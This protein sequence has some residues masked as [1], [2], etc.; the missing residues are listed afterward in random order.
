MARNKDQFQTIRSQGVMLPPDVLQRV[1]LLELDGL[2]PDDFHLPPSIRLNEAISQSWSRVLAFWKSFSEAK[3]RISEADN[4]GSLITRERWLLPLFQELGYGRLTAKKAPE[5][6]GNLYPIER[7]WQDVPIHLVGCKLSM[8][9]RAKGVRGAATASPHSLVQEFLNRSDDHLWAFVSNGLQLRILRDNLTLS[10]QSF[11]EFNLEAMMDGEVYADFALLWVL[12]HQSRLEAEKPE[13]YWLEK[14]SKVAQEQGTRILSDLRDGVTRSIEALGTG[15]VSHRKNDHLRQ[16]LENGDLSTQDYYRQLLRIIYRLLFLFVSEDRELLHTS[17]SDEQA[18]VLYDNNYS[19]RHLRDLA[20][21]FRGSKHADLWHV[22]SLISASLAHP[23]GCPELGLPGLGSFLWA[24]DSTPDLLGPA[25]SETDTPV[26]IR[27]KNLLDAIRSLAYVERDRSLRV[28]DYRSLGSEEL[29]SVY[30]SLLELVPDI[31]L[32]A[33]T[34]TL[35][36]T[37]GNE[38]KTTGSYYTPDSLVQCLLDSALDPVIENRLMKATTK[39]KSEGCSIQDAHEEALLNITVCDPAVGSGH[40]LIAAAHR[41][42][43]RL[44]KIR[45]GEF[46]SVPEEYQ[47]ALRDVIRRCLYGVDINPMAAELCK[48]SL[49][50]ESLDVGKPLSF[51]D[52]HIKVGNA[53]LGTT[54]ALMAEGIP[55]EAFK[56]LEGDNKKVVS[57]YKKR[58]KEEH[59]ALKKGQQQLLQSEYREKSTAHLEDFS[60]AIAT[61]NAEDP[62][63][64]SDVMEQAN[65]YSVAVSS[66]NYTNAR[67][68]ADAWCAAFVWRKHDTDKPGA[69]PDCPGRWD[70]ITETIYREIESNPESVSPKIKDEIKRLAKEYQFF[71]WHLEFPE[72]FDWQESPPVNGHLSSRVGT[73]E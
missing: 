42:A 3:E 37:A 57:Y 70:A 18:C 12:C 11:V 56:A 40:F 58:N 15:F 41:L 46:E 47:H 43:A 49:W 69:I 50:I 35:R 38:R 55:T 21:N 8:D 26:L 10:R 52:H 51:L 73:N 19:T 5:I 59:T 16:K 22:F 14:W 30:E 25:Q 13:D 68:L 71:H 61:I 65:R 63:S 72:V 54:P 45:S 39:A 33:K 7:F 31:D 44:A 9:K 1:A 20:A 34:F 60:E 32:Q 17:E 2:K 62:N 6:D 29:G 28:V 64:V 36:T 4:T 53:L 24:Y 67:L 27:N 66:S 48:V 23:K